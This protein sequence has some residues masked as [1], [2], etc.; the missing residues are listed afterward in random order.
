MNTFLSEAS[1]RERVTFWETPLAVTWHKATVRK[2]NVI[3]IASHSWR[4]IFIPS[5]LLG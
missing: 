4:E 1:L 5:Q 2:K 3:L